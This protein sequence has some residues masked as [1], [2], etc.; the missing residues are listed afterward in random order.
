MKEG[1]AHHARPSFPRHFFP[2]F[3]PPASSLDVG[4][5]RLSLSKA[6]DAISDAASGAL[7]VYRSWRTFRLR[8]TE[9]AAIVAGREEP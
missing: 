6:A 9:Q 8:L 3:A 4:I 7:F 1:L 5:E 2:L